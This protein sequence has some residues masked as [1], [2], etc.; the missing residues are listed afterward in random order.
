MDIPA[1]YTL[2]SRH[3]LTAAVAFALESAGYK[4]E[5]SGSAIALSLRKTLMFDNE[6]KAIRSRLDDDGIWY[7]PLKGAVLK[8]LYPRCGM[9]EFADYDILFDSGRA[10]DVRT[11]MEEMGYESKGFGTSHHDVYYK[12]PFFNFEMHRTLFGS[13]HDERLSSYFQS[14]ETRLIRKSEYE[15]CFTPEDFYLYM[16][17]H[18]YKHYDCSGTGLRSLLDVY[19]YLGKTVLDMEYVSCEAD[20][21]GLRDF[22]EMNRTLSK[23][24]FSGNAL[25]DEE[26]D[27]LNY[28]VSSG[29]YGTITHR[30]EN[31]MTKKGWGKIRYALDRFSVPV[32]RKSRNYDAYAGM[33]PFFYKHKI[34]LPILPFYRTFRS[35]KDGRFKKEASAIINAG[36]Q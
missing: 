35:M 29:S 21:L 25:S 4:D 36:K 10:D 26:Q 33:Y 27:T 30:I 3:K 32:S 7:M 9:R 11:I 1:V 31:T 20:K 22:E 5:R 34:L 15:R 2:A 13:S 6:W 19:V 8:S 18:E 12:L 24:L 17:S 28:F 14:I 16:L 23:H